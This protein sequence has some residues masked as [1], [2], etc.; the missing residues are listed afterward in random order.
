MREADDDTLLFFAGYREA[1]AL[2]QALEDMLCS[3]FPHVNRRVQKT[4]ITFYNSHGFACVSFA[5][6]KRVSELPGSW[7]T[8][9]LGLPVPLDSPR[10]AAACEPYPGRWTHHFVLRGEDE[11]DEEMMAW[12]RA[13]YDFAE[14]KRQ[15]AYSGELPVSG[16]CIDQIAK[17]EAKEGSEKA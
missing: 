1:L 16:R 10:V 14:S 4:Q 6:V 12:I 17:N 11:L 9:T 5:R 13:S 8:L 7:L 3:S 15:R 2:Y